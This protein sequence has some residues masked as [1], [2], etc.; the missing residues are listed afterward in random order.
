MLEIER[1]GSEG[2][3]TLKRAESAKPEMK[4]KVGVL[5]RGLNFNTS[6]Q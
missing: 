1:R 6:S 3:R 4:K 5:R 2:H